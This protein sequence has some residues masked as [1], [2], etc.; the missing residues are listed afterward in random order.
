MTLVHPQLR[1]RSSLR[2]KIRYATAFRAADG[3]YETYTPSAG[4]GR[5]I[6]TYAFWGRRRSIGGALARHILSAW[7]G[8]G[9][10]Y[11]SFHFL[12]SDKFEWYLN[13]SGYVMQ[14]TTTATIADTNWHHYCLGLD[15]TQ[16]TA[17]NRATI[18]IDGVA[19]TAY[20]TATYPSLDYQG[21][22]FN[23]VQH[24]LAYRAA[25]GGE[26]ADV[27][28]AEFRGI[29]GTRYAASDFT[30]GSGASIKGKTFTG[31]YGTRGYWLDSADDADLGK[32]LSGAGN[33]WAETNLGTEDRVAGPFP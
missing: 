6:Y 12:T 16:G 32:D 4:A 14:L 8:A 11:D 26:H 28:L 7:S 17:A 23:N 19:V 33:H 21:M 22:M 3:S 10:T 18:E 29:D 1:P 24:T 25:F 30:K 31:S 20:D 15:T 13:A 5:K 9:G 2:Y 27:D